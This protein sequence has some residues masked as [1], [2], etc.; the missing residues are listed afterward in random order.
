[1]KKIR[2]GV[3]GVGHLGRFH[4][5]KYA[6]L[7]GVDLVGVVDVMGERA[8]E[9]ASRVG[10]RAYGDYAALFGLVDAVSIATPTESHLKVGLEFLEKGIDV[11]IEKPLAM[12]SFEA[13]RLVREADR[14]GAVLQVG[15]LERFNPAVT[16]LE[17]HVSDPMFIEAYRLAPFPGRSIDIDVILDLMIHDIDIIMNLVQADVVD[18][19]ATGIPVITDTVDMANARLRFAN[20]CVANVTASRVS[21]EMVRK[22]RLFQHDS[23]ITIDYAHQRI[24]ITKAVHGSAGGVKKMLSEDLDIA[25][26]DSLLEEIRSFVECSASGRAPLVTGVAGKRA[27]EVAE[28]IQGSVE[29]SMVRF[30]KG[31]HSGV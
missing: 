24:V 9:V 23:Y 15:H 22:T 18:V 25:K 26:G 21:D 12:N 14:R 29:A 3:V 10:A 4:A 2:A 5:E 30:K 8:Q 6:A 1:M 13:E 11:L 31:L 19:K 7:D 16:A 27:I 20:G 28:R 17:G